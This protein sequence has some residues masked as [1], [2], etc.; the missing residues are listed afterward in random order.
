DVD[1]TRL[2]HLVGEL[3]RF[4]VLDERR[5][6]AV[7]DRPKEPGHGVLH[8]R[9]ASPDRLVRPPRPRPAAPPPALDLRPPAL[10]DDL[11]YQGAGGARV[12]N[13]FVILHR[14]APGPAPS[15]SGSTRALGSHG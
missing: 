7:Q 2:R 11:L 3:F 14:I 4:R 1:H 9:R 15:G 8:A 5:H 10:P 13:K 6:V 12:V